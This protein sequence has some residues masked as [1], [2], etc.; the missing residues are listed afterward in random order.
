M[1]NPKHARS[2]VMTSIETAKEK[3]ESLIHKLPIPSNEIMVFGCV[4]VNIH[5]KC[6]GYDTARKWADALAKFCSTVKVV[7]TILYNKKNMGTN[8]Q[9][10]RRK[11]YL[12]GAVV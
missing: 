9:P 2:R 10:S 6:D 8:L 12:I 5:V 11:G 7:E 4:R 3:M 1:L